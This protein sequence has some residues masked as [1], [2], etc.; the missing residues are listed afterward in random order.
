MVLARSPDLVIVD[1][2]LPDLA[3]V[4]VARA[5]RAI[6]PDLQLIA[7][8][9][10]HDTAIRDQFAAAGAVAYLHGRDIDGLQA[11]LTRAADRIARRPAASPTLEVI[12]RAWPALGHTRVTLRGMLT[13]ETSDRLQSALRG[14]AEAGGQVTLDLSDVTAID[15]TGVAA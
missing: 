3:G 13:R 2:R 11:A 1:W 5:I 8:G 4:G 12:V 6:A 7:C 9:P 15:A 10:V 14:V